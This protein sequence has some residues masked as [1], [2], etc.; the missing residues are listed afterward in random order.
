MARLRTVFGAIGFLI[1]S[2]HASWAA[3][4]DPFWSLLEPIEAPA[5][6]ALARESEPFLVVRVQ[7]G[8]VGILANDI[9]G[10]GLVNSDRIVIPR[11]TPVFHAAFGTSGSV[12]QPS[13]HYEG[14][15]GVVTDNDRERG[16]CMLRQGSGYGLGV[17]PRDG[18]FYA[19]TRL[20]DYGLR[21]I[22]T[23]EVRRDP[24]ARDALPDVTFSYALD[25]WRP[26]GV[27]L[28]RR[29]TINGAV[30]NLGSIFIDRNADRSATLRVGAYAYR[31]VSADDG[32][33]V[34]ITPAP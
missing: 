4:N 14:W 22:T 33:A 1:V 10:T 3:D 17:L 31:L 26:G 30:V 29:A 13:R 18:S 11:G 24:A 32:K 19:P 23:P 34:T 20:A 27:V 8:S 2:V 9:R 28:E 6:L 7:H 16:Y 12:V 5:V 21:P 25:A 15:C